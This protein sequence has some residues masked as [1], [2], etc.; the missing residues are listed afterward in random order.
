MRVHLLG[1]YSGDMHINIG[2]GYDITIAEFAEEIARCVDFEGRIVYDRSRPDGTP[3]KLLDIRRIQGLGW[4]ART[5]LKEGLRL[6]YDWFLSNQG[7]LRESVIEAQ[8][9]TEAL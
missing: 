9:L 1:H 5:P 6:Y 8:S 4:K 7:N 2:A 3:R